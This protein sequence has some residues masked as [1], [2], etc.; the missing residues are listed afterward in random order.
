MR[1]HNNN[2]FLG[3]VITIAFIVFC[4]WAFSAIVGIGLGL[5]GAI[6][7]FI[8]TV[9]GFFLTKEGFILGGIIVAAYL[10]TKD[11]KPR[12]RSDYHY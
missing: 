2:G 5:I 1:T 11:K 6:L 12:Y 3:A 9:L 10:I 4:L 7:G 8:G